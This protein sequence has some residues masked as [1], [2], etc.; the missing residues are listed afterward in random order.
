MRSAVDVASLRRRR[1]RIP[2]AIAWQHR[3]L[4]RLR[5]RTRQ[6]ETRLWQLRP[7]GTC[8]VRRPAAISDDFGAPRFDHGRYHAHQGNDISAPFGSPIVAPF[9]GRA[10]PA[11]NELG[12]LA[13]D[14]YGPAGHVYNAHLSALGRLGRVTMGTVIGYVGE[15][16]NATSPHDHFEW[17]P[18]NGAAID[19]HVLLTLVCDP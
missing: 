16:G 9:D 14:V 19:P 8:P 17:H 18:M 7:I 4:R 6:L 1:A 10:I 12:G 15:S 5:E 13:V 11:A 2:H 3:S